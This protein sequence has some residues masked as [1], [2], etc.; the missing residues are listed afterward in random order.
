ME[1][2]RTKLIFL[3]KTRSLFRYIIF[4][5]LYKKWKNELNVIDYENKRN[6]YL[7][8]YKFDLRHP[9][10]F[11]EYICY[12]KC[13][14]YNDLWSKCAD[15]LGSKEFLKEIGLEKYVPKTYGVYNN[16]KEINLENLPD[17]FVLK[18]NHDCGSVFVCNKNN[19]DFKP[20]FKKLDKSISEKY[21]L[22]NSNH[23]WVYDN[24]RPVIFAEE[25]LCPNN[26]VDLIDF[27]FFCFGGE[28]K[29]GIVCTNRSID[30]RVNVF[31]V[32]D[33]KN[34]KCMRDTLPAKKLITKPKRY[35]EAVELV[36]L[37]CKRFEFVRVDLYI[38][39]DYIKLGELTFFPHSGNG[40]FAPNR[41][42]FEFGKYFSLCNIDFNK[43]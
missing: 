25:K 41:Y 21:S 4:K 43:G 15:K 13:F 10:S 1:R 17:E 28:P 20:I 14:Y 29:F 30:L 19:T 16:S 24:I 36:R 22:R 8:G 35:E 39:D 6:T 33:F 34:I 40:K 27:K 2:K 18:T 11:N 9:R 37:I 23:E 12:L 38:T 42:D 7:L 32:N 5:L 3:I 26:G 31:S